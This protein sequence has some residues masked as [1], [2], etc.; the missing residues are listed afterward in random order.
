MPDAPRVA[1][2]AGLGPDA[3][4]HGPA[5]AVRE[6]WLFQLVRE[7]LAGGAG[8]RRRQATR[9]TAM[10]RDQPSMTPVKIGIVPSATAPAPA[11]MKTRPARAA[12]LA[13]RVRCRTPSPS[14]RA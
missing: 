12:G 14:S 9:T 5:R 2:S 8:R 7:H 1:E 3:K 11:S 13:G 6:R 4:A 10:I